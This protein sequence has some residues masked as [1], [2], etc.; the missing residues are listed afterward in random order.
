MWMNLSTFSILGW[1]LPKGE[2][3]DSY[4]IFDK[5]FITQNIE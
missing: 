3:L 4:Y 5:F 2:T 1:I